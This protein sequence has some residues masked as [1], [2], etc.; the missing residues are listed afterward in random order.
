MTEKYEEYKLDLGYNKCA[1]KNPVEKILNTLDA[2]LEFL[3][4]KAVNGARPDDVKKSFIENIEG[5]LAELI[6]D[7]SIN[8]PVN[9]IGEVKK[10]AK[11]RFSSYAQKLEEL[12]EQYKRKEEESLIK[13]KEPLLRDAWVNDVKLQ[14][15]LSKEYRT[16]LFSILGVYTSLRKLSWLSKNYAEKLGPD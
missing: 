5:G 16:C 11:D 8:L 7:K 9:K 14:C 2:K 12:A 15:K 3:V 6:R 13:E 1:L 4:K 10:R